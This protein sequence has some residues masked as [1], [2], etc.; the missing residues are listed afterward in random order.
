MNEK[1]PFRRYYACFFL[2]LSVLLGALFIA[3]ACDIY[4]G[5]LDARENARAEVLRRAQ[6]QQWSAQTTEIQVAVAVNAIPIYSRAIVGRHLLQLLPFVGIWLVA[7]IGQIVLAAK[8]GTSR[9]RR[10]DEMLWRKLRTLPIP[11]EAKPEREEDL[12][13]AMAQY[14]HVRKKLCVLYAAI[15]VVALACLV[16]PVVYLC[17]GAHFPGE[18]PTREVRRAAL[19]ALPFLLLLAAA[20]I[21]FVYLRQDL[22]KKAFAALKAANAAAVPAERPVRGKCRRGVLAA[23]IALLALALGLIVLGT[24]NGSMQEVLVKAINICTECIGLG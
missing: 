3:H 19:Y 14:R 20:E 5:A 16:P 8:G 12:A 7:L 18:D 21:T 24:Q 9:T 2:V 22:R 11:T 23:R 1:R 15:A 10:G 17:D 4:F 6:T 13:F